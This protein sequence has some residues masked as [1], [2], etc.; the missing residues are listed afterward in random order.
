MYDK[1]VPFITIGTG[2]DQTA[3]DDVSSVTGSNALLSNPSELFDAY[4]ETD[5]N[6][7]TYEADGIPTALSFGMVAPPITAVQSPPYTGVWSDAISDAS[8]NVSWSL[9]V[10]LSQAHSSALSLFF[11][12]MDVTGNV[13]VYNGSTL[14]STI[15][16]TTTDGFFTN[17]TV[18]TYTKFVINVQTVSKPYVHV[19]LA[20]I[21]FGSSKTFSNTELTD[22]INVI[23]E[24]DLL[25][26]SIPI[27]EMDF[28]LINVDGKYDLDNV[29]AYGI[30]KD[31]EL[32]AIGIPVTLAFTL[33]EGATQTTHI[34]GKYVITK[35]DAQDEKLQI[36]AQDY[37][38]ILQNKVSALNLSTSVEIADS[39]ST[40]LSSFNIPHIIDNNTAD[41][42]PDENYSFSR[43]VATLDQ[44]LYIQQRYQIY[45]IPSRDGYMHIT[46]GEP[47]AVGSPLTQDVML[48]YPK[49]SLTTSY[50]FITIEYG[51]SGNRQAYDY[52]LRTDPNEVVAAYVIDN[53]LVATLSEAQALAGRIENLMYTQQYLAEAIGDPTLEVHQS[54]TIEGR[55]SAGS[56][57]T[58]KVE[59]LE[60]EYDGGLTMRVE[61][62]R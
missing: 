21:E 59:T 41:I 42:Y 5:D 36:T 48:S 1:V 33:H 15:P 20:E 44:L 11:D 52:D 13:Q 31:L 8:G 26:S 45:V 62:V 39:I 54:V 6:L 27:N 4:Y 23:E 37:R 58:Y 3:A 57:L 30:N 24:A 55:F 14:V 35:H 7:A 56:P 51:T 50:N 25:Q 12:D 49:P 16:V 28:A 34:V 60:F 19:R 43:D 29:D 38:S 18:L 9:T 61:G 53:P 22:T 40:M 46:F 17:Q 10:T 2:I 32:V 47:S